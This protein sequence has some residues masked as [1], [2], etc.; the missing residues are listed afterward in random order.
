[1]LEKKPSI[2]MIPLMTILLSGAF[3]TILNQT[4][5]GTALPVIMI[6]LD[7]TESTVQWLQSVFMLVNG[8]MIPVTAFL[9]QR[10]S[11]RGLFLT[12][13]SLFALGTAISAVAPTFSLL[14]LG[15][16]FQASGAGIMMPLLQTILFL[17]FPIEKRGQAMGMFGLIIAFAPAIGPTLS[18]WL[19]D[20]FHWR[21]VFYVVLPIALFTI[22]GAFIFLK[23]V[24]EQK[25]IKV[26]VTSIILSTLGFG[27]LLYGF[28][29]AGNVGWGNAQVYGTMILGAISLAIFIARQLKLE[30]PML[31]FRVFQ[32]KIYS[33]T[34]GLSMIVFMSMIGTAVIL[35]LFMQNML[36]VSALDSGLV[37]LPGAI[38]TGLMNPIT[39]R[40][41][42]MYG[43]RWL[44]IIGFTI[45]VITTYL[46]TNLSTD[47]SLTYLAVMNMIRMS[48]ISMVMM[49]VTTAGLNELPD[50]L[51]P[52]GT[53][54]SNTFRQMAGAIGTA[55]LVTIMSTTAIPK[56][57]LNGL[58]HGVNMSF[59][60]ATALAAI[61][62]ILSFYIKSKPQA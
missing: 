21:S 35:P 45:L 57:G 16:I 34:T 15:R 54:M 9:I 2:K 41:F 49:P 28:S 31:E 24:T 56:A 48:S 1:M 38:L 22:V 55:V 51:I 59:Y 52:H 6:D 53:A 30:E 36:E 37:L 10:F 40:L 50:Y 25:D 46:F 8:I 60:A 19:V 61:G 12:A 13:M 58:I 3:I 27:G 14:M 47:T 43:A 42:D 62:L 39:G 11:T 18:G 33:L 29:I 17:V 32:Y 44:A 23:N 5:L 7:L 20:Q 4:L 26:D